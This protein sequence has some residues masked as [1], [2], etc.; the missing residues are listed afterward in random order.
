MSY[1]PV[2]STGDLVRFRMLPNGAAQMQ[3][4][5][6]EIWQHFT[7]CETPDAVTT[8]LDLALIMSC[9]VEVH[10][11]RP[12]PAVAPV[13]ARRWSVVPPWGP[14]EATSEVL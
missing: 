12:R 6:G 11:W 5:N 10:P 8:S 3:I 1:T 9:T 4:W 13:L 14:T 7:I 2:L